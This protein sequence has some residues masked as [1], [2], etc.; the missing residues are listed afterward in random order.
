MFKKII[1][2]NEETNYSVSETGEIRN[3][4]TGRILKGTTARNEYHSVQLTINKKPKTFMVH[5]LVAQAFCPNPNNYTIVDH[6]D[7]NKLNNHA[8]NLQWVTAEIN[9]R[10]AI[11]EN[12]SI[13]M[14]KIN[15]EKVEYRKIPGFENYGATK[16][17]EIVNLKFGKVLKG[18][19]R[20]GYE[21]V[22]LPKSDGGKVNLSVHR[23]VYSAFYGS[24]KGVI[25]HIDGNKL[26]NNLDNLRDVTQSQNMINAQKNGH[27]GQAPVDQYDVDGNFIKSYTSSSEA[28]QVMGVTPAAIRS[29]ADRHGSSCGYYWVRKGEQFVKPTRKLASDI[30]IQQFTLSGELIGEYTS[31]A[32][33]GRAV[34]KARQNIYDAVHKG[35]KTSG[36]EWKIKEN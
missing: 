34:G 19:A 32:E 12:S 3:D 30:I 18:Y 13:P 8:D 15:L 26:N 35:Y 14:R 11:R 9:T 36:Y 7:S 5:R 20:D 33:A 25:D 21:R 2:D 29:A 24:I 22:T 6:I 23:L 16:S 10:K 27:K 1:I 28:A 31:Y 4:K 17:G